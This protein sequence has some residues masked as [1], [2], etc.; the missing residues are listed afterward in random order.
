VSNS[1]GVVAGIDGSPAARVAVDWAAREAALREWPLT[2]VHVAHWSSGADAAVA[3]AV[4]T[5][6]HAAGRT[7]VKIM[8]EILEPPVVPALIE[9]SRDAGMLV[10]GRR[11]LGRVGRRLLG[12][13]SSGLVRDAMCPVAVIHD[14]DP[15]MEH[16]ETAPVVVGIDGSALSDA[17][18]AI[19][20]DEAE[21]RG[22]LLVAVHAW[23][24]GRSGELRESWPEAQRAA[25]G[26][27][28]GR[29]AQFQQRHPGVRVRRV[30][31]MGDPAPELVRQSETAQLT[32]VGS[33]GRG[34]TQAPLGSVSEAVVEAARMP[35]LVVRG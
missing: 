30:V 35:V 16:P 29:L 3:D 33:R 26:L 31:V 25:T 23:G 27:L 5:A 19:A 4:A 34:R 9:V 6:E 24:A 18:T 13:V 22:V 21:R 12:S 7:Q 20:F 15:L 8:T 32:V 2:I 1:P 17:A 11:G 10:V 28:N 14:E